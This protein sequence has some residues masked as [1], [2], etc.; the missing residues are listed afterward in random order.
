MT[1][2][3]SAPAPPKSAKLRFVWGGALIVF[4]VFLLFRA[5]GS[6]SPD[7]SGVAIRIVDDEQQPLPCSSTLW[8]VERGRSV[9]DDSASQKCVEGQLRW[10]KLEHGEYRIVVHSPGKERFEKRVAVDFGEV[11]LGTQVLSEGLRIEGRVVLGQAPVAG[12][13]V[14]VEG[15]RR[16]LSD[17][18]GRFVLEGL[19]RRDLELRA[20]SEGARGSSTVEPGGLAEAEALIVLERGRGQGLLGLKV[21]LREK[22]PVVTDLLPN[23]PAAQHLEH[24]DL[25]ITVDGVS[26][27]SLDNSEVAQVLAGEVGS[28]SRLQLER[29]GQ[30]R[31]VELSRIAPSALAEPV[32]AE[33]TPEAAAIE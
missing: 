25:L 27:S 9:A 16:I 1:S 7:V 29:A 19:P 14:L 17:D 24:G 28:V 12:A 22:G 15:G 33:P 30:P 4:G 32:G 10:Q 23:S 26:V 18:E 3:P 5:T 20:A 6:G 2:T 31:E 8:R 11:D 21:E 13:L